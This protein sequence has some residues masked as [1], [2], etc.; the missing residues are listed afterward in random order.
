MRD[1]FLSAEL[2]E[3]AFADMGIL[4]MA[5]LDADAMLDADNEVARRFDAERVHPA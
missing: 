4:D 5:S 1:R 3:R 2:W